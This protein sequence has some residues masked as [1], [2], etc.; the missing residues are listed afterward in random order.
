MENN[1]M[2][3][4]LPTSTIPLDY[5]DSGDALEIDKGIRDSI[6]GIQFSTLAIGLGLANIKTKRFFAKL[7]YKNITAYIESICEE[8]RVDRSTVFKWL[9]IGE[10]YI[11][12][13]DELEQIGFTETDGPAKLA[14]LDRALSVN[15]RKEVFET[16]KSMSVREFAFYAKGREENFINNRYR[17]KWVVVEKGNSFYVN[18]KLALII[19]SKVNNRVAA[20]F[21]KVIQAACEA[22][23]KEGVILPVVLKNNRELNRFESVVERIKTHMKLG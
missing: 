11:K 10:A 7:G 16:V 6:R 9:C 20:Y 18:G 5:L 17:R 8:F 23:E 2:H 4:A 14:Y 22:L 13:R 19:S 3:P 21:K 1:I 12:H 15:E